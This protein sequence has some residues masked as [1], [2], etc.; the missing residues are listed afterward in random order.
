MRI[1]S[2]TYLS[3]ILIT[4]LLLIEKSIQNYDFESCTLT[5]NAGFNALLTITI[6]FPPL[7]NHNGI[8]F[9]FNDTYKTTNLSNSLKVN[10]STPSTCTT[11][12]WGNGLA[13]FTY[14]YKE[15]GTDYITFPYTFPVNNGPS[16]QTNNYAKTLSG[17][18][19]GNQQQCVPF[20]RPVVY[21][22][23]IGILYIYIYIYRQRVLH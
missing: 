2:R 22:R 13:N 23:L 1:S 20:V 12:Y 21:N 19:Y 10:G 4:E 9:S 14:P 11:S 7:N 6:V 18:N 3:I 8:K 5:G 16:T 15:G 17:S